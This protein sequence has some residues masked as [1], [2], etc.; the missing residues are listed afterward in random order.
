MTD[1]GTVTEQND[2]RTPVPEMSERRESLRGVVG[3]A[4]VGTHHN[5]GE[6]SVQLLPVFLVYGC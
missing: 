2:V 5:V 3:Q 6:T 1:L 4:G